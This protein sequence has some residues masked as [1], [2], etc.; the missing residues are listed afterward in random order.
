MKSEIN[1][2]ELWLYYC[3]S[4]LALVFNPPT[5]SFDNAF[6]NCVNQYTFRAQK[7]LRTAMTLS[8]QGFF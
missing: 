5:C 7:L 4:I 8:K 1:H 6:E 3:V 2:E